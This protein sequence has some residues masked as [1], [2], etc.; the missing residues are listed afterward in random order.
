M[1]SNHEL[2]G[3]ALGLLHQ[4]LY[5]YVEQEMRSVY[6]DRWIEAATPSMPK[7][8]NLKRNV[9]EILRQDVSALLLVMWDQWNDVF[10]RTLSPDERALV[11]QLRTTRNNWAHNH[12]FSEKETFRALDRMEELLRAIDASE[13]ADIILECIENPPPPP[14]PPSQMR[15][16]AIH[17]AKGG[18]GKTTL[19]VN[20]AYELAKKGKRVLVVDLDDSANTSL[21]L[22][23]NKADEIEQADNLEEIERIL[24][25]FDGRKELI[26]FLTESPKKD[27]DGEKYIYPSI[28]FNK[29][30]K[31]NKYQGKI[32]I[33]PSSYRT[34][35]HLLLLILGK[36]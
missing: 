8:P 33:I 31:E 9:A 34:R 6:G 5:P 36:S 21:L 13:Q 12:T 35:T 24:H 28:L 18:V 16:I 7:D 3:R 15:T 10:R 25:S 32:S 30:L 20:L 26:D 11:R 2:V 27:F 14:P 23:V 1:T 22:G 19:V 4:G 17:A 29:Y